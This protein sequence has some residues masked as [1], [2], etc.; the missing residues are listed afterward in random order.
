MF[1]FYLQLNP[2]VNVFQRKF[3]NE[4]RRCEEMDRK[5]SMSASLFKF[6]ISLHRMIGGIKSVNEISP[7]LFVTVLDRTMNVV[8]CYRDQ[9][10]RG[11]G[12][13]ILPQSS[14]D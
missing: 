9:P 6:M 4:V 3:V 12:L 1:I 8:R 7:H 2:D 5:L 11:L 14:S 10:P 13:D